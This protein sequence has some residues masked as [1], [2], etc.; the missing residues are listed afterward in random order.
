[1]ARTRRTTVRLWRWRRNPL[2]RRTDIIEAWI[3][4][5]AGILAVAGGLL[6]G[7]V[8]QAAVEQDLDRQRTER[9]AV[10]ALLVEDAR[11]QPSASVDD[12]GRVWTPARWRAPDGSTHTGQ[13]KVRPDTSA[14]TRVTVWTDQYGHIMSKP[15]THEE[16]QLQA[17]LAGALAA[18]IASGAFVGGAFATRAGLDRRRME[19]WD[20]A[21]VRADIRWGG[22]T[23]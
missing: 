1:M 13:T 23:G 10:A 8:T 2:R 9:H 22:K 3:L 15:V 18:V 5:T 12:D 11:D 21:W 14:G 4:L 19:Q 20:A 6:A 17:A 16:A 7:L